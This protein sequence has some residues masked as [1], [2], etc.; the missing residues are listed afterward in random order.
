MEGARLTFDT[1]KSNKPPQPPSL[2]V[3]HC[4]IGYEKS[5]PGHSMKGNSL[6]QPS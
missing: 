4:P 6:T 5:T 2:P 1:V 3:P